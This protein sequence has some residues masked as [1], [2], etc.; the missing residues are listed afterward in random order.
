MKNNNSIKKDINESKNNT[1]QI[2][3]NNNLNNSNN[4]NL[5]IINVNSLGNNNKKIYNFIKIPSDKYEFYDNFLTN[6]LKKYFKNPIGLYD[7]YGNNINPLTG[8]PYQNLY[9][10]KTVTFDSGN[11]VGMKVP[12][13]YMNWA[14]IWSNLPLFKILNDIIKSIRD[15]NITI[16]KAGTGAGKSFLGGR[17]CSQAFNFQKK[18]IMTLPKKLLARKTAEDTAVTCDVV[19]GE[20]VGYYFKGEYMVDKNNKES[21]IVFTTTGSLIRKLTGDDPYLKEYSCIIIDEAHERTVQTDELI[22]F[23]KKALE[24][25]KDLKIVF[26]S[27]TLNEIEFKNYFKDSTFNIVDMGTSTP[28]KIIDYYEKEKPKDWHKTA[29]EKIMLILKE[30]KEGDILV[31]IKASPDASKMKQ[32]LEPQIKLLN[33][34]ENP[35]ITI[36]DGNTKGDDKDYAIE[37]FKYKEHPDQNPLKPYTRKI[38]FSTNVAESSL[39]VK[40]AVFVIDCGLALEDLYNPLKNANALLEKFVSQS[41]IMQRRG[42]VGRTKPGICYH[43][44]SEKELSTFSK[45]PLPSIQKS[46]IT[47]D[48][49]DIMKIPYIKN[50][51]DVKNLLNEMMSPP[52]QKFIDSAVLNLYTMEAI[53]S[54]DDNAI[55]TDLGKGISSFSGI[56][57]YL[58]RAIIASYYYHC[59]Y[60]VIP[61]VVI[62]LLL[63]GR[64]E[65]IYLDYKPK[66]KL[67][68]S[69]YKKEAEKFDK[70][71]HQF[72]SKYGDF[73]TVHNIYNAF[74]EYMKLPKTYIPNTEQRGGI[75]NN[76]ENNKPNIPISL[77]TKKTHIDAKYW[78]IDNGISPRIFVNSKIPN[79]WDIVGNESRK[80]DRTLMDIIQPPHL[81]LNNHKDYKNDGGIATKKEL[82]NEI[83]TNTIKYNTIDH[84]SKINSD[85][86]VIMN[87]IEPTKKIGGYNNNI[88][89]LSIDKENTC[90]QYSGYS[91]KSYEVNFFPNIKLFKNNTGKFIKETNILMSLGHGLFMNIAKHISNKKYLT[92]YPIEKT[93]CI[94]D[95]KSTVS[96]S[97]KP[98]FLFYNEL[99]MLREGQK[100]LKLNFVTKLPTTVLTEIKILYKKYIE[101][102]YKKNVSFIESNISNHK[103]HKQYKDK[104]KQKHKKQY[105]QQ[106][107]HKHK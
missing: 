43:L 38:V 84:E 96:L 49:L 101:D 9:K 24:I 31:F 21:K 34:N 8:K 62:T 13:T 11:C 48:I 35:F 50:L 28:Q 105:K 55:L 65:G 74:R 73:L 18:V 52:E 54:K 20:E 92:C 100:E 68:E 69:D 64:I 57:I 90:I 30:K 26:I 106:Y 82:V 41:A 29:V 25:R 16:L 14:Y 47:L 42:R 80:I 6:K 79:N 83:I 4:F 88:M 77:Q 53:S 7:P 51:S 102:C 75:L 85:D 36:L 2:I 70:K 22:L 60:D 32:Y 33:T 103:H 99:F 86:E 58:A 87:D 78:C 45:Y 95:Q 40:G 46:D 3:L 98:Q 17:I 10:D 66:T 59:K 56:P 71:K 12:R 23:L 61:I 1:L 63:G 37:E 93:Y 89:N 104:Y 94:P 27:A 5:N 19:V 81:K 15:N 91:N 107:K 44:Y 76:N 67:S 97:V 39:T 72:D